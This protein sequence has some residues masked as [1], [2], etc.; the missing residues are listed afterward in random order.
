MATSDAYANLPTHPGEIIKK[1]LERRGISQRRVAIETTISPSQLNELIN[2]KR[3]LT[4]E[5]AILLGRALDLDPEPLLILQVKYDIEFAQRN[6]AFLIR[7]KR[8][9]K[10]EDEAPQDA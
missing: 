5:M 6:R 2:C 10:I 1:E 3:P 4:A 7:M 9:L 8:V